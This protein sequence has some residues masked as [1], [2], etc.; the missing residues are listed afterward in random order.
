MRTEF[1]GGTAKA[2]RATA[3][4]AMTIWLGRRR[5]KMAPIEIAEIQLMKAWLAK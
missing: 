2:K 4:T 3:A 1:G 5:G